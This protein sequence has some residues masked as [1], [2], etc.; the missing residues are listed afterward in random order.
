MLRAFDKERWAALS[1]HLDRALELSGDA[2]LTWLASLRE[3]DATLASEV[4]ALLERHDVVEREAFLEFGSTEHPAA[5]SLAGQ[6]IGPYTLR[7]LIGQGGMGTVWLA[8]R[9]D[10][11]FEGVAA[12][13]LLNASLM[14]REGE[15]RFR[16]EGT[17]LARLRHPHI[18]HLIDAGLSPTG[19]PYLI[20][21]HVAGERID[22]SCDARRL[23]TEARVTLFL[24]VLA[25]VS[26][27]HANL[28]VHRDIKPSNVMVGAD[29]RVKLLDFGIAKLLEGEPGATE[30]LTVTRD[31][32]S[33]LTPEYAAPEQLTG[34]DVTTAT[35]VHGLGVLLYLLLTG[36]HPATG[37][38]LQAPA[39]LVRAIV[40][41]EARPLSDVVVSATP[42]RGEAAADTAARRGTTPKQL[43]RALRGD[44]DNI[45]A[46]ALKKEPRERYPSVDAMADDLRRYLARQPIRA[47]PDS[48][49]YRSAKFVRR[50]RLPVALA[51]IA[52]LALL[53]GLAGTLVQARRAEREA[54]LAAQGR[55]FAIRQ[56]TRAEAINDLNAFLLHDAAPAG[57]SLS[58]RALLARAEEIVGRQKDDPDETQAAILVQ[59]GHLYER[60]EEQARARAL[61]TR[62]WELALRGTDPAAR[63]QAGCA[64]ASALARA[65]EGERADELFRRVATELPQAPEFV[66]QR[67]DCDIRRSEL[68][69]AV[70]NVREAENA[71]RS[72]DE[73]GFRS[74]VLELR[75]TMALANAYRL[76]DR[77]READAAFERAFERLGSLGRD[78]TQTA[79]ELL[80]DWALTARGLGHPRRAERLFRQ[81]IEISSADP[82]ESRD[83]PLLN[84]LS[85]VLL[86]LDRLPEATASAERAYRLASEFG[87][88]T[89]ILQS[90]LQRATLYRHQ[91]DLARAAEALAELEPKMRRLL[92]PSNLRISQLE[93]EKAH[94][95]LERGDAAT[96][97]SGSDRAVAMA[98]AGQ[99]R[100]PQ[101]LRRLL[102]RRSEIRLR[103]GR[104]AEAAADA[105]RCLRLELEATDPRGASSYVGGAHLAVGRALSALGRTG[106]ARSAFEAAASILESTLGADHADSR[107]AGRRAA[108]LAASG[109]STRATGRV[110]R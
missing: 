72:L 66:L 58:V 56:L 70:G 94:L 61:L 107:E 101:Y 7:E 96:A 95:A 105:E 24:D 39:E 2:R 48:R 47:R 21:E 51:A 30:A 82:M 92:D 35:D 89:T 27:A 16:R 63:A 57:Q 87:D 8:D 64:L 9:S 108:E 100:Q 74:S 68:G 4:E 69:N 60:Q 75:V 73:S 80:N 65:G 59:L 91:G 45:V 19:Q 62:A 25:A 20:L 37:A 81:A 106:E 36:R 84:N 22:R 26:H 18:A 40:V 6:A 23:G 99:K 49:A 3:A 98:E 42:A 54:T 83:A 90:L 103:L 1:P 53:A 13:K 10:G 79:A 5:P 32:A 71:R 93:M 44:L 67:V 78:R 55:D 52:A 41:T 33:A 38:N 15:A 50:N 34:G 85:R 77:H 43:R 109:Q 86:D 97:L 46:K 17:I 14:G 11:R 88:T 76:A 104:A 102:P 110:P 31:G 29:G 12:V 28:I